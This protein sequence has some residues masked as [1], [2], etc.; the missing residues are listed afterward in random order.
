MGTWSRAQL[1]RLV[2]EATIDAYGEDEEVTGLFTMVEEHLATPFATTVLGVEVNVIGVDLTSS[3]I[4]AI[5]ARGKQRQAIGLLDLPL[6][7]PQPSGAQWIEAYR[8]WAG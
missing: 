5:C 1:D 4:V 7:T 2:E 3:G 8:H 6:P